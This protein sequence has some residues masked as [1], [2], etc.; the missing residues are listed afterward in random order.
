MHR[1]LRIAERLALAVLVLAVCATV[2]ALDVEPPPPTV[3]MP[4]ELRGVVLPGTELEARPLDDR[5]AA[6]IVRV[7]RSGPHGDRWRYDL[8]WYG[9]EPGEYD[10]RTALRRKDGSTTD[11]LPPLRV[12]VVSSLSNKNALP[13]E[14]TSQPISGFGNYR[15][16]LGVLLLVWAV[17][18]ALISRIGRRRAANSTAHDQHEPE[19]LADHLRPLVAR[20]IAGTI[21]PGECAALE[22]CL[23][24]YW[25]DRLDLQDATPAER[26]RQLRQH[27]EASPL[28][29]QL[30]AWLHEPAANH[31]GD[32]KTRVDV[33]SL[34]APYSNSP[35]AE[36]LTASATVS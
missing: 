3:G 25:T 21:T 4:R 8:S 19:T 31:P 30:E 18:F 11:D 12:K 20:G 33:E 26:F 34:L 28:V 10:L 36:A 32:A 5:G 35:A 13:H 16:L 14:L 1:E 15:K 22:R 2:I 24:Q 9:L 29:R 23:L 27:P 7:V 17:G 6:L